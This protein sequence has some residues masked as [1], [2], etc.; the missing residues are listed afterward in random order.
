MQISNHP[1]PSFSGLRYAQC[2]EDADV[3]LDALDI[4]PEHVC[5][6]IASAGDNTLAMLARSP[7][8][9]IAI[10]MN[11]AQLACLELRVAAYAVLDHD[12]LLELLG[13]RS[14]T[15]RASL[16]ATCRSRLSRNARRFW[17]AHAPEIECGVGTA[18]R[19]ERYLALFRT[20]VLPLAHSPERVARLLNA[21]TRSERESFYLREWDTWRWRMLFRVFFSRFVMSRLGR[22]PDLFRYVDG[23]V[24]SRI[25]ERIDYALTVLDPAENP[26]LQWILTGRCERA[27]PFAL[28]AENFDAIR[29][30]LDR[31]EWHC[32][33]LHAFL[34]QLRSREIDRCNLSDIF[35]Y[36]S[37]DQAARTLE[38]LARYLRRK[39]RIAY[40]NLL[41]PRCRPNSLER[42]LRP[43]DTLAGR[44]HARDKAFFYTDFVVEEAL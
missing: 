39:A 14:S 33:T 28:R 36:M 2:W 11:P 41:V 30:N 25:L 12:A 18:G 9:V 1:G 5:L 27:L 8:R 3:L 34:E 31:L 15:R 10:D 16:Y 13:F 35:E 20:H 6:S 38:Q 21:G 37:P 43:L 7:D 26:Y 40:W 42:V 17:D 24:A 4:G 23:A 22:H 19:F 29:A 32:C 44:L